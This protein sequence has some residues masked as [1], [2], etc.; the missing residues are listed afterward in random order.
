MRE[1]GGFGN[2]KGLWGASAID[3]YSGNQKGGRRT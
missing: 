2:Q 1:N 3:Y